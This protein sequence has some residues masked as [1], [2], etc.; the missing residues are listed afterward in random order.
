MKTRNTILTLG[1][2]VILFAAISCGTHPKESVKAFGTVR[3]QATEGGFFGIVADDGAKYDPIYLPMEYRADYLRVSF[4]A[5]VRR[6]IEP[7]HTWGTPVDLV[8]IRKIDR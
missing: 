4:A 6:N 2:A 7:I 3:F 1:A 5:M 8:E